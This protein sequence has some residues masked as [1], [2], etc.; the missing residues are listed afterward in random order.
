MKNL[1]LKFFLAFNLLFATVIT[2]PTYSLA[3]PQQGTVIAT[4][5]ATATG[6]FA[7]L[8]TDYYKALSIQLSGT[9]VATVTFQGSNDASTWVSVMGRDVV[10]GSTASS[11]MTANGMYYVPV[12]FKFFRLNTT[13]YTSGTVV[14]TI[15]ASY[16]PSDIVA[17]GAGGSGS[18]VTI[19]DGDSV[20]LGAK[21]DAK[22]TATDSTPISLIS[23]AKQ[24]SASVQAPPSQAVTNAGTFAVQSTLQAGTALAGI[25]SASNETSTVYSGTTALTPKFVPISASSS[26]N[27]TILAAVTSKKIRVLGMYITSNGTVNA[28][29]QSGAGGTDL[30]GLGYL[31]ANAGWVLP[32]SP[33]GW[34][35]TAS[36]TLLNLNLSAAI[37]VGGVLVYVE[38]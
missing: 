15:A 35:E 17:T 27:N 37:A 21:A 3:A 24:I 28:K 6:G 33:I 10:A 9:W 22:S 25:V 13:A 32:Y 23:I 34:F 29:F 1:L 19:A 31:I 2:A 8:T 14:A 5:S 4:G 20:T 26:G 30:T 12:N 7:S 16:N 38:V 36:N 18:A 11:T